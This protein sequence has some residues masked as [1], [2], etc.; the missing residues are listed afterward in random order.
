MGRMVVDSR[1]FGPLVSDGVLAALALENG[2]VLASTGRDYLAPQR[3]LP[4]RATSL[5]I[6]LRRK[7]RDY[8]QI[9]QRRNIAGDGIGSDDF[10]QQ[11]PHDFAASRFW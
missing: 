6:V 5:L 7:P 11:A 2:A 9:F 3:A 10:A 1:A 8:R 4:L